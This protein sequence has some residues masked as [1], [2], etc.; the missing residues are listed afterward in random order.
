M[1]PY[2]IIILIG[3]ILGLVVTLGAAFVFSMVGSYLDSRNIEKSS[4][5]EV[6]YGIA[7]GLITYVAVMIIG[8]TSINSKI[9]GVV[10]IIS[11]IV[12]LISTGGFGIL[13]FVILLAGGIVALA[14]KKNKNPIIK[15]E[16]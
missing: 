2:Q 5:I 10:S 9:V 14:T 12:V 4:G 11:S 15:E 6:Y 8:M 16:E 3:S 13:G 1:K 7:I